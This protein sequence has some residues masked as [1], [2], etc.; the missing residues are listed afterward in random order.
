MGLEPLDQASGYI[1]SSRGPTAASAQIL[2]LPI[3]M[4]KSTL[5]NY[6]QKTGGDP[7]SANL[8]DVFSVSRLQSPD[9]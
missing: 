4:A 9:C 3:T 7:E 6:R 8:H 2:N 5:I 1:S